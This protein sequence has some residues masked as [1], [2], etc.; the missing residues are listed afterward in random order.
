MKPG[1]NIILLL[2]VAALVPSAGA[3]QAQEPPQPPTIVVDASA[4]VEREPE[5]AVL[6]LAVES[7]GETAR[8]ASQTNANAMDGVLRALL[9]QGIERRLIR[10]LSYRLD[11]VYGH[12]VRPDSAPAIVGYR[13]VNMVQVTVDTIARLGGVIDASIAAGAN[14]VAGLNYELRDP[15]Q[16]R[17]EALEQAVAKAKREAEVVAR[18]AGQ[19]LG[20]P[21]N[22]SMSSAIP[23]PRPMYDM[24]A[25]RVEMAQAATPIEGGTITVTANVHIVYRL[26]RM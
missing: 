3:A 25:A 12:R 5:R 20:D 1:L 26:E 2:V 24:A 21:I 10:T 23:M 4:E 16:A 13:A 7:E 6:V 18:A 9:E 8:A 11:P 15:E 19:R 14:R 22:I 17:L